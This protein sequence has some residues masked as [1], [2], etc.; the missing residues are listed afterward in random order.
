[1]FARMVEL[2]VQPNKL[3]NF[4]TDLTN[5]ILPILKKSSGF[6]D[7]VTLVSETTPNTILSITMWKTQADMEKYERES[8][9]IIIQKVRPLL[10]TEPRVEVCTVHTSTFHR[11]TAGMAA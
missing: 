3:D 2:H 7:S 4:R 5:E 9:P 10:K 6:V 1:M 8:Y 11:I